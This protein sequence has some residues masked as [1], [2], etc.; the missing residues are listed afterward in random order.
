MARTTKQAPQVPGDAP[1]EEPTEVLPG[2]EVEGEPAAPV[3]ALPDQSEID[4][5][6][7]TRAVMTK[8]GWVVPAPKPLPLNRY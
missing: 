6:T 8:Q 3:A 5:N 1:Q 7:I 4:T 2:C